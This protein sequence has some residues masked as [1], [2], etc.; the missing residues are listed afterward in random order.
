M[1]ADQAECRHPAFSDSV[2]PTSEKRCGIWITD[3]CRQSPA[4]RRAM[5]CSVTA[6]RYE[7]FERSFLSFVSEIDLPAILQ[8][9]VAE[10][11]AA[12]DDLS[13]RRERTFRL[14]VADDLAPEFLKDKLSEFDTMIVNKTIELEGGQSELDF[15][16]AGIVQFET[17]KV[18]LARLISIQDGRGRDAQRLRAQVSSRFVRWS[19]RSSWPTPVEGRS[20][21]ERSHFFPYQPTMT[22]LSLRFGPASGLKS[23]AI[24][25]YFAVT[26]KDG[27]IRVVHPDI[28]DP[29][30]AEAQIVGSVHNG[31]V[32]TDQTGYCSLS[33]S[34]ALGSFSTDR[35]PSGKNGNA[36][37]FSADW[38]E[39]RCLVWPRPTRGEGAAV[40]RDT[41]RLGA[42]YI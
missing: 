29:S 16:N 26:F 24:G 4:G 28:E 33:V 13:S 17:S 34:H 22:D 9:N 23:Q 19:F 2:L 40:H 37:P 18:E 14:L 1:P 39:R 42:I 5:D 41:V 6:W 12:L 35:L 31:F 27:K 15:V 7:D 25:R 8:N 20:W 36:I 3:A 30:R 21:T 11:Q 32:R 10:M 38:V